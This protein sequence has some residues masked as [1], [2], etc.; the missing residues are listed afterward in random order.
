MTSTSATPGPLGPSPAPAPVNGRAVALAHYA[1][2]ALL[3]RTL[4]RHGTTFHQSV[5]LRA[6]AVAGGSVGRDRL[7]GEVDGSLKAGEPVVREVI[8]ELTAAG[9][10]AAGEAAR[11]RLTDAGRALYE[12]TAAESAAIA[13]RLYAGIP[14]GDLAAAGRVLALVTERADAELGAA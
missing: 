6:V 14:A 8:E 2:R 12:T 9:L 5:T 3:E 4:A 13:A 1:S 10:L 7:V 11:V